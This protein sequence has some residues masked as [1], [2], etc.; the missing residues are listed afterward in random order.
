[1]TTPPRYVSPSLSCGIMGPLPAPRPASQS[2]PRLPVP[3]T[4]SLAAPSL[5]PVDRVPMSIDRLSLVVARLPATP[6]V[7]SERRVSHTDVSLGQGGLTQ[8]ESAAAES[9]RTRPR[10]YD[11]GPTRRQGLL[12]AA[13]TATALIDTASLVAPVPTGFRHY[14]LPEH[15]SKGPMLP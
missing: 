8:G 4:G 7:R 15:R 5:P 1:M 9:P 11:V 2:T 3:A 12:A 10:D 13:A 14:G 6:S